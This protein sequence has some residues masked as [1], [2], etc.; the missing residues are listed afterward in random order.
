MGSNYSIPEHYKLHCTQNILILIIVNRLRPIP[1]R[2]AE[3]LRFWLC[4][5]LKNFSNSVCCLPGVVSG[6]EL[7]KIKETYKIL[8]KRYDGKVLSNGVFVAHFDQQIKDEYF[9]TRLFH[10]FNLKRTGFVDIEEFAHGVNV[11]LRGR[12]A[13]SMERASTHLSSTIEFFDTDSQKMIH[14]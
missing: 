8:A 4:R 3:R 9:T 10:A 13:P 6:E 11:C 1:A 12:G 5:F 2:K 7:E 14:I